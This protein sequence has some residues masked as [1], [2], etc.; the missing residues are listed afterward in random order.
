MYTVYADTTMIHDGASPDIA[1]HLIEPT[2]KIGDAIAGSFD[3]TI[4]P[5]GPGYDTINRFTT[6]ITVKRD[7]KTLWV[8]RALQENK[9]LWNRR[10]FTCEGALAFL[11]DTNQE[12][13]TYSQIN[14]TSFIATLLDVH[15]AK[16]AT[17]HQFHLGM[18][19]VEDLN[20]DHLYQTE[21]RNTWDEF[22]ANCLDRLMGHVRLRY[23]DDDPI[24]YFDYLKE[25]PNTASQEINFG[26]N[27]LD[28]TR[29]W[30]LTDLCTVLIPRGKQLDEDDENGQ[31]Q[32]VTV[33]SVNAGSIYVVNR[34]AY[35]TFG[36][37]EQ[38]V[39]FSEVDDPSVLLQ[40]AQTYISIQQFDQMSMKVNAVDLHR[41]TRD[42]T[43]YVSDQNGSDFNDS[44]GEKIDGYL[45]GIHDQDT[46]ENPV[47][48]NLLDEVRCLSRPH[49][50]DRMFPI[51]EI[52][53][54]L[55]KPEGVTYTMGTEGGTTMSG[56]VDKTSMILDRIK[57]L[58]STRNILG[59]AKQ[60]AAQILNQRTTGY[61]TITE[62][63]EQS[64]AII[65]S[66]TA[67]WENSTKRW[68]W[69]I[70][71][72][73]YT[74]DGGQTY[75]I[76]MT[77]DGTIVADFIKT[78]ILEDG[79]GLNYWN[80]S[81]GEF[82][83]SYN[84]EFQDTLG[85][86]MTIV[87]VNTLAQQ[88]EDNALAAGE[89]ANVVNTKVET[90]KKKQ[91]GSTNLL[92]GTNVLA[93]GSISD[94][95]WAL[96]EW[97]AT[98]SS[99]AG[100]GETYV[101]DVNDAP[102]KKIIIGVRIKSYQTIADDNGYRSILQCGVPLGQEQVYCISCYAKGTG[103]LRLMVGNLVNQSESGG[104]ITGTPMYATA[105]KSVTS[106]WRRY[107]LVFAT[108]R[109]DTYEDSKYIAGIVNGR[110]KVHFGLVSE[111][112]SDIRICGM[113]LER[114]NDPTDWGESDFDTQVLANGYTD[115]TAQ[116]V[117]EASYEYANAQSE[118]LQTFTRDYVEAISE[119][120]R[121]FTKAQR[122]ALD[123]S[124]TQYKILERLTQNFTRKGIYLQQNE[125][126]VNASYIRTGTLDAG[127]VKTGIL[128][129]HAGKNKWNM[130]TGYLYTK[131]MEAVNAKLD[132]VFTCGG[133]AYSIQLMNGIFAGY[134]NKKYVG[135]IDYSASIF[136][137]DSQSTRQGLC[138]RAKGI[139]EFRTPYVAVRNKNDNGISTKAYT[140][141]K[142]IR[143]VSRVSGGGNGG[144]Q[145]TT[146]EHGIECINGLVT[147]VW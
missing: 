48:F 27:L 120:D 101:V 102:N 81:T 62:I 59:L 105:T 143:T 100:R 31:R 35:D 75:D 19:T 139:I 78:G 71:G 111:Q 21:Y 52:Q 138:V 23:E 8:G 84:T 114:G 5:G 49:G 66:N 1:A 61:V 26:H 32:Y 136:D 141:T 108:G 55:D 115:K 56:T 36:R 7:G 110:V 69:N 123:E 10:K 30:D 14:L 103:K 72:L 96:G 80:L 145:T 47:A 132:G 15:N 57:N 133:N 70:N 18:I 76:A 89:A 130:A 129:D 82:S 117:I 106:D 67:D 13:H 86:V 122:Q 116:K 39:D 121:E 9:D 134:Q 142:R 137:L 85:N 68:M 91:S 112:G 28:F 46:D 107:H 24:P 118:A 44:S 64:Q 2:L 90:E 147:A 119:N 54:P 94:N 51:T 87:D 43:L 88:A 11:N 33:A 34:D 126:Y 135:S 3:F 146:D 128:T 4:P 42:R 98:Y 53:I 22:K 73:G 83:L 99:A 6:L 17:T 140:G 113:K 50:L 29:D 109:N 25:Y 97:S 16:V 63:G 41:L 92:N 45:V 37:I 124:F 95:N 74:K 58:P 125:L 60:Q 104:I 65:I 40:L 20:D 93:M 79:Y 127:I 77:M 131:N 144:I 38:T 12:M